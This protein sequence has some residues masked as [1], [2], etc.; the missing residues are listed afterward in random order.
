MD[1]EEDRVHEVFAHLAK[2]IKD[3]RT[4]FNANDPEVGAAIGLALAR[5]GGNEA[6]IDK[7]AHFAKRHLSLPT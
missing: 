1:F 3:A 6:G 4:M 5:L 2:A 7:I